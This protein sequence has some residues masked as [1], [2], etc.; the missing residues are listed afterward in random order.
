MQCV[1]VTGSTCSVALL[2][3]AC[4]E[5]VHFTVNKY[6]VRINHPFRFYVHAGYCSLELF[7]FRERTFEC[8]KVAKERNV[9]SVIITGT[10]KNFW[11]LQRQL[12][13]KTV[14]VYLRPSR[15]YLRVPPCVV[16]CQQCAQSSK[17]LCILGLVVPNL[18][19][20]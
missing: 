7:I 2:Y 13:C 15:A 12:E 14:L 1:F 9:P 19:S 17:Y 16:Q 8:A 6:Q 18:V 5:Y 20:N 11:D 10:Q 3:K 4:L